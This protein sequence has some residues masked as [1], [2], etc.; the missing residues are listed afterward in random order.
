M[1]D[2]PIR[3]KYSTKPFNNHIQYVYCTIYVVSLI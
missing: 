3:V 1:L 2:K